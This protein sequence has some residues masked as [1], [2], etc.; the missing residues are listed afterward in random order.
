MNWRP[1][2]SLLLWVAIARAFRKYTFNL[3]PEEITEIIQERY[4]NTILVGNKIKI[5][6]SFWYTRD[7]KIL[8]GP[9]PTTLTS[10]W[11]M[12]PGMWVIFIVLLIIILPAGLAIGTIHLFTNVSFVEEIVQFVY[13][14]SSYI[15]PTPYH[16]QDS[17]KRQSQVYPRD[18]PKIRNENNSYPSHTNRPELSPRL[19]ELNCRGCK[20]LFKIRI[21]E[22]VEKLEKRCP[23]C[24]KLN[25][26]RKN[27]QK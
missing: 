17:Y 24:G 14:R 19:K 1:E 5:R 8:Y 13:Y 27:I 25:I 18:D 26:V 3:T 11:A 22:G 10:S 21:D 15:P 12:S 23:R 7:L 9:M 6:H 2:M 4:P 20:Y 16:R